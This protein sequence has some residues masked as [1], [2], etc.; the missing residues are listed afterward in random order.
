MYATYE[1]WMLCA[2]GATS[3]SASNIEEMKMTERKMNSMISITCG[4]NTPNTCTRHTASRTDQQ[5]KSGKK[6]QWKYGEENEKK[7]HHIA[8]MWWFACACD[9]HSLFWRITIFCFH[10]TD[11]RLQKQSISSNE[12]TQKLWLLFVQN[13]CY[14]LGR[15]CHCCVRMHTI[16][17]SN[18]HDV[19]AKSVEMLQLQTK[20]QQQ[21]MILW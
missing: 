5:K 20:K 1:I 19:Y 15:S 10:K 16:S 12:T 21:T 2:F 7:K 11:Y 18:S 14:F 13:Y 8:T 4:G 3:R 9:F 6:E 17:G